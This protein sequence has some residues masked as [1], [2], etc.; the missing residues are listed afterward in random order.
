MHAKTQLLLLFE[1]SGFLL[2]RQSAFPGSALGR[3]DFFRSNQVTFGVAFALE[4]TVMP[5]V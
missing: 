4:S 1:T 2:S 5:T 3:K